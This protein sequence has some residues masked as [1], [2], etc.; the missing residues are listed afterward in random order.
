M[1]SMISNS[2]RKP[3]LMGCCKVQTGRRWW[4]GTS[5]CVGS[6]VLLVLLPKCPMCIAAYLTLW[7]GASIAMPIAMHLRMMAAILFVASAC[8]LGVRWAAGNRRGK[9]LQDWVAR[10]NL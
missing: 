10:G 3:G 8:L 7:T 9:H 2:D 6:G 4:Q 1:F 5:G